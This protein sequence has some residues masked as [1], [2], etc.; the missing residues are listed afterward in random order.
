MKQWAQKEGKN[1]KMATKPFKKEIDNSPEKNKQAIA[2][3]AY[4]VA[5][6]FFDGFRARGSASFLN[7]NIGN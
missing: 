6:E 2:D 1:I 4:R 7:E 3:E 5:L